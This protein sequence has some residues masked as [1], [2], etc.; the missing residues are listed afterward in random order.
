MKK[1]VLI[2]SIAVLVTLLFQTTSFAFLPFGGSK[3][4]T[5]RAESASQPPPAAL[6]AVVG[7]KK[8]IAVAEFENKTNWSGQVNLGTGMSDQL[9]TSL[10][11]TGMYTVLERE[12]IQGVLREQDFA[13]SGR[14]TSEG[15]AKIGQISRAQIL[16][17]GSI[18]EFGATESGGGAIAIKGF[19]FGGKESSA[20]VGIDLRIYDTTTGHILASKACRGVA[21]SSG[22]SIGYSG[23]DFG[24]ATGGEARTPMDFAVRAAIDQ[25]VAFISMELAKVP[26][27]GR[28]AMVKDGLVYVN[29]GREN[30]IVVGDRFDV[31]K[32]GEAV[33]DPESGISLGAETTRVGE[34]EV[35]SVEE[36]F[37]KATPI[38]GTTFEKNN[39][40]KLKK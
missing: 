11:N 26:W 30:G 5:P 8:L 16:I 13:A 28:V 1:I 9:I 10:M 19:A 14:T 6:P 12:N 36:K 33:V 22:S 38:S 27:A 4:S 24:F 34:I 7:P 25:A 20:V 35:V 29:A 31:F 21:K 18:T 37:S 40:L 3:E 39:I 15:G 2:G 17:Q 32:E 23:G